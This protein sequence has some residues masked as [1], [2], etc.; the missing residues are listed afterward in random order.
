MLIDEDLM[1]DVLVEEGELEAQMDEEEQMEQ[2]ERMDQEAEA[3]EVDG[4]GDLAMSDATRARRSGLDP[5]LVA[6]LRPDSAPL[7]AVR[8]P[9]STSK[10]HHPYQW[11]GVAK[12]ATPGR[13]RGPSASRTERGFLARLTLQAVKLLTAVGK[14]AARVTRRLRRLSLP[15]FRPML[16]QT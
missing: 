2:E 12:K 10:R 6:L 15:K 7:H 1:E 9:R 8:S 11:R 4:E 5:R 13:L 3:V 14:K 16:L